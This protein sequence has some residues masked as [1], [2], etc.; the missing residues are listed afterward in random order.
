MI[1]ALGVAMFPLVGACAAIGP[2]VWITELPPEQNAGQYVLA[3]GDAISI[4]VLGHDDMTTRARVRSDGRIAVPI[5]GDVDVRGK[6]PSALRSELQASLTPFFNSASVTVNV[7]EFQRVTVTVLGEVT[8]QGSFPLESASLAEALSLAGGLTD[9]ADRDRLFIVRRG[10][11]AQRIRF[12]YEEV[13]RGDRA[14]SQFVLRNGDV[15]V[16]E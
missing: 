12:T 6:T 11:E 14:A 16:V 10:Q 5:L 15:V 2:Y 3:S 4:R 13:S 1:R 9:F 8:R 7:E